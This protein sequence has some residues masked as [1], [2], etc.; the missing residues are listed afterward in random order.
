VIQKVGSTPVNTPQEL[1]SAIDKLN[2]KSALLLITRR[3][4]QLFL[5][6]PIA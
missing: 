2:T 4:N 5:G 3:N 1:A 6:V